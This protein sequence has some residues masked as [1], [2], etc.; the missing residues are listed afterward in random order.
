MISALLFFLLIR[1]VRAHAINPGPEASSR[2]SLGGIGAILRSRALLSVIMVLLGASVFAT[3][4]NFQTVFADA[5]GLNYA[6]FFLAYTATVVVCRIALAQFK[7]GK[8]PYLTI[9]LLQYVMAGSVLLF[10]F[11]GANQPAYVAVAILFGIGYGA[12]YPILAAAAANDADEDLVPQTLQLFALSY[13]I[14]IFAFPL[15][16][17]WM[18]VEISITSL[19]ALIA[20]IAAIEATMAL[21]RAQR[22]AAGTP[23][24]G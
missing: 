24:H 21:L 13:F 17:G 16:A 4:N 1:P 14:G 2:L 12:S 8:R 6:D 10:I 15:I 20:A 22:D 5:R 9:S 11:S 19:L 23:E 3:M 18:I 7:G